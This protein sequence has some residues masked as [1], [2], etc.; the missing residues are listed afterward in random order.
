MARIAIPLAQDFEDSEFSV[1]AKRLEAAGHENT[2]IGDHPGETVTG[3]RGE[4]RATIDTNAAAL[5]PDDFDALVIPG[6]YSPDKLRLDGD[7]VATGKPVAAVCHGQQ[8]L[9]E[10]DAV[11]GRTMTSWPSVRTDLINA[12]AAW[13]DRA[14]AEDGNLITSR[15]PGDL[16]AFCEA[17]LRRL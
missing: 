17:I 4:S 16:D 1:P 3:K 14:V 7:I 13:V 9:I 8:L 5:L 15:K 10:A 6:G 12:G 2:V 11:S